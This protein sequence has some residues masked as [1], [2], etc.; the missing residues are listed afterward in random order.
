MVQCII[1]LLFKHED[2]SLDPALVKAGH[3][4]CS[5]YSTNGG[6][7]WELEDL[8]DFTISWNFKFWGQWEILSQRRRMGGW[9][10]SPLWGTIDYWWM[11]GV[12]VIVFI[13]WNLHALV[14]DSIPMW[15]SLVKL[16]DIHMYIHTYTYNLCACEYI[17]M[18]IYV[19]RYVY[20]CIYIGERR[21]WR[22]GCWQA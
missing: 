14:N 12:G 15:M 9:V 19:C 1:R 3:E 4:V 21:V 7:E 6:E 8:E 2:M 5:Q 13:W 11:L 17:Y 16:R 18:C 22:Q 10:P 20:T